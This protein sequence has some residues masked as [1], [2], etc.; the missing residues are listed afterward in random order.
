[1]LVVVS[2]IENVDVDYA[3]Q[4]AINLVGGIRSFVHPHDRVV[5]KPNLV[6]DLPSDT[7]LTTD[8]RVVQAIIELCKS[9]DSLFVIIAE[10]SGGVDTS[11]A[12]EKCGYKELARKFDVELVDLN[13]SE[14]TIVKIPD[15][16]AFQDLAVPNVVLECDVLINVPKLKFFK[17]WA[18]LSI[19]NLLGVVP[20]RGEYSYILSDEFPLKLSPAYW[21][22]KGKFFGPRGEK[23][24]V[25]TN[26][27]QGI[28]DLNTVIKPSLN[29]IDGVI[30]C[31]GD[32]PLQKVETPIMLNTIL[33]SRDAL[34][35]DFIATK[36]A[37]LKPFDINYLKYAA[38]RGI[39]ESDYNHINVLG[40]TLE[41][42]VKKWKA[43]VEVI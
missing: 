14:C 17:D 16:I 35:L 27:A 4:E 21:T 24:K 12:F 42:V 7:G 40:T 2:V 8:P 36:I 37:G 13:K 43:G 1:M 41:R 26:F 20:G 15:G 31:Y 34:A 10:G 39:G 18:S 5:I 6:L 19:K 29:V 28:V 33:A 23:K 38:E 11:T 32:K 3:V 9:I 30:A 22:S 25:H